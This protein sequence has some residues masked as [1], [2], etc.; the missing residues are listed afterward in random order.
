ML[1]L[2]RPQRQAMVTLV[3]VGTTVVPTIYVGLTV[4]AVAVGGCLLFGEAVSVS[5]VAAIALI[6]AGVTVGALS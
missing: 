5:R 4:A 3:L 6:L 2:T 1:A